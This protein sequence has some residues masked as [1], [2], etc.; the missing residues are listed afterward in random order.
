MVVLKCKLRWYQT[1]SLKNGYGGYDVW[2]IVEYSVIN[3]FFCLILK[4]LKMNER[5]AC[6]K[7]SDFSRKV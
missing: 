5:R 2:K 4:K 6:S 3:G 1:C 7:K